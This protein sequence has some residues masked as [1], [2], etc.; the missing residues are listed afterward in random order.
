MMIVRV[1]QIIFDISRLFFQGL[2]SVFGL[3]LYQLSTIGW[4]YS[5]CT[6]L[7][8]VWKEDVRMALIDLGGAYVHMF[9][10]TAHIRVQF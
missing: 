8:I 5:N 3:N 2:I 1:F 6:L 4:V 9:V 7:C 10:S